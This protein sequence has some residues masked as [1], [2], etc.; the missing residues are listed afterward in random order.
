MTNC[1]LLGP[2]VHFWDPDPTP[3]P[4]P[5]LNPDLDSELPKKNFP[6]PKYRFQNLFVAFYI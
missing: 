6:I 3:D 5:D 2:S 4:D 1:P